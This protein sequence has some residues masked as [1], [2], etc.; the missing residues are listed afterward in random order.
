VLW[1]SEISI[2]F[3]GMLGAIEFTEFLE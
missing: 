2:I 1:R 3:E